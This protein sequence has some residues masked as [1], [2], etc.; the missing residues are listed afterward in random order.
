VKTLHPG[1]HGGILAIRDNKQHMA[2]I[3]EH[4]IST[5]DLVR[6]QD[7]TVYSP[8]HMWCNWSCKGAETHMQL[9]SHAPT[10]ANQATQV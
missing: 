1:V 6:H 4:N 9:V 8:V 7:C 2:A 10:D 3:Q 5:I